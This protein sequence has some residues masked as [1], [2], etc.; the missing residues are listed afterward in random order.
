MWT[1]AKAGLMFT[2]GTSCGGGFQNK[3]VGNAGPITFSQQSDSIWLKKENVIS[4]GRVQCFIKAGIK[5]LI[6]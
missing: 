4:D 5:E 6:P 2:L 1:D 3:G